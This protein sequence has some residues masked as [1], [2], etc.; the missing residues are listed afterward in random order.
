MARAWI[1]L[2]TGQVDAAV[3]WI[4]AAESAVTAYRAA[5][6]TVRADII[7]LR[8]VSRFKIGDIATSLDL[9][10]RAIDLDPSDSPVGCPAVYCIY[11]CAHY[12]S[13]HTG[14]A[15]IAYRRAVHLADEMG[16]HIARAYA[17]G[18][19][20]LISVEQGR[21]AEAA[22]LV[23]EVSGEPGD[24]ATDHFVDM[25]LCEAV[26]KILDQRGD[27]DAA[28]HNADTAV[29]LAR[30]G[31]GLFELADALITRAELAGRLGDADEARAGSNRGSRSFA[32]Q[33][34]S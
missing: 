26:A 22:Q 34:R 15:K 19:L 21:W 9:A 30:R 18:Y 33:R 7:V 20:A 32:A 8:A 10:R 31:G 5:A 25:M 24:L 1:A 16:N 28:F 3:G 2:D 29:R 17:F 11:G 12:W 27:T 6:G 13:G 23:D 14:E 4:E